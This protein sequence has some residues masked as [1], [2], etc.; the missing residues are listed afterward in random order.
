MLIL[1]KE[2]DTRYSLLHCLRNAR[3]YI[4]FL[5]SALI[6]DY[7]LFCHV[8][9]H[10]HFLCNF[11]MLLIMIW[12][13][14]LF[15]TYWLERSVKYLCMT[16]RQIQGTCCM[17]YIMYYVILMGT[18][19]VG[20]RECKKLDKQSSKSYNNGYAVMCWH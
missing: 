18:E 5:C 10:L 4:F 20:S 15:V 14:K 9:S 8:G 2:I 11:Q 7:S 19:S 13:C 6:K 16:S 3:K 12:Y 17:C 1:Y